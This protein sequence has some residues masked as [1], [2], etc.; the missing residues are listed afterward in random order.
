MAA[1][2]REPPNLQA[3]L[4]DWLN[5]FGRREK[6]DGRDYHAAGRAIIMENALDQMY[7][8]AWVHVRDSLVYE[9]TVSHEYGDGWMGECS[10]PV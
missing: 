7:P 1:R 9:C 5:G 3:D 6:I 4:A 8:E 10:C 2:H